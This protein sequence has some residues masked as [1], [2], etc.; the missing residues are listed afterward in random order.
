VDDLSAVTRQNARYWEAIAAHRLGEPAEFFL[1]GGRA[2]MDEE[3]AGI[4]DLAGKR[5][6]HLASAVG[7]EAITFAQLGATVTAVDISPTHVANGQAKA[8]AVGVRVN[9]V[10]A[11]MTALPPEIDGFDVIYISWGGLCWVPDLAEWARD[12]ARRLADG[13]RLV[14]AE[15]HPLWEVLSVAGCGR[16]EVSRSYFEPTAIL[17]PDIRKA[18]QAE[19]ELDQPLPAKTSFVWG[20]GAVVSAVLGAGLRLTSLREYAD[21]EGYPGLGDAASVIPAIYILAARRGPG[22]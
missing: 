17:S 15:H 19:R 16:L 8:T 2:L 13:G 21:P 3:L 18:P 9:F 1:A 20:L 12:V 10:V 6:L 7:N 22:Q 4:G 5:V 14:I 11:D